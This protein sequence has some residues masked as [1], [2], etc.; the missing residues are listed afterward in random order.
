LLNPIGNWGG[1]PPEIKGVS[2][3]AVRGSAESKFSNWMF[4]LHGTVTMLEGPGVRVGVG[5]GIGVGLGVG[6]GLGEPDGDGLG[7][8]GGDTSA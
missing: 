7:I 4:V 2:T 6:V 3:D 8:G 5:L 1:N